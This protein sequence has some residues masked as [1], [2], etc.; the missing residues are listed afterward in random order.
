MSKR[1]PSRELSEKELFAKRSRAAR[2]GWRTRRKKS[3]LAKVD[4]LEAS[5]TQG[6]R[7]TR[8]VISRLPKKKQ[9][10]VIKAVAAKPKKKRERLSVSNREKELLERI[11]VLEKEREQTQREVSLARLK[12]SIETEWVHIP[13][14]TRDDGTT[15]QNYSSLR[16]RPERNMIWNALNNANDAGRLDYEVEQIAVF[17]DVPVREVYTLFYSR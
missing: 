13:G 5:I 3:L 8:E 4:K 12:Y 17:Y 9:P 11:A 14:W 7:Q 6:K 15:A 10:K 2:K 16:E 1:R